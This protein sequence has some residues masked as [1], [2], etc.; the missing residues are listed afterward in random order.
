LKTSNLKKLQKERDLLKELKTFKIED[1][2]KDISNEI[3]M[4]D[5]L[6]SNSV[7]IV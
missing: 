1:D 4:L 7:F 2:I 5:T 6:K 3:G